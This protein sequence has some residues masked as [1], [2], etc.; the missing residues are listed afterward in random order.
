MADFEIIGVPPSVYVRAAALVLEERGADF[1]LRIMAPHESKAPNFLKRNPFGRIPVFVHGDFEIYETQAILRYVARVLLGP[2][3]V[4]ESPRAEARMNQLCGITDCYVMPH[5]TMGIAFQRLI[6]PMIG[7]PV[8]ESRIE[9]SIPPAR[10]CLSEIA[11]ILGDQPFL[12]GDELCLADLLLGAHLAFF[13]RAPEGPNMLKPHPA[14]TAW[15]DRM[16][17]RPSFQNTTPERLAS[18]AL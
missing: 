17:A 12:C 16:N 10:V 7:L 14:L 9:T 5:L 6:A 15:I 3:L 2:S 18:R 1:R 13:A 8:D 11:Q 4:P